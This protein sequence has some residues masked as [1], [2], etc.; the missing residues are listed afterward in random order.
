MRGLREEEYLTFPRYRALLDQDEGKADTETKE[1]FK[2][3]RLSH[4]RNGQLSISAGS[5]QGKVTNLDSR[6]TDTP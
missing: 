3:Q 1:G 5:C 2:M 4:H 6:H